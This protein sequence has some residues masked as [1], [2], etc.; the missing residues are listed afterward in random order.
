MNELSASDSI[1][2]HVGF[3]F[4]D[5]QVVDQGSRRASGNLRTANLRTG[6]LRMPLR[7]GTANIG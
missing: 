1:A 6:N 7:T 4:P 2:G 5:L 3:S